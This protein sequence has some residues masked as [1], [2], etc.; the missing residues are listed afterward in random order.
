MWP[1]I[2]IGTPHSCQGHARACPA[3][4]VPSA[5]MSS[6][7]LPFLTSFRRALLEQQALFGAVATA[8]AAA[9]CAATTG[10]TDVADRPALIRNAN[11]LLSE[12]PV[13]AEALERSIEAF[14]GEAATGQF[15]E[16]CVDLS[17]LDKHSVFYRRVG[18]FGETP[19][20]GVPAVLKAYTLN[21]EDYF[22]TLSFAGEL[23][24]APFLDMLV[25]L[26]A[27]PYGDG[28]RFHCPFEERTRDFHT[29]TMEDVRFRYSGTFDE[30]RAREF[31]E[32]RS[33]LARIS[34]LEREPLEYFAF[35]SLDEMLKSYGLVFDEARC[36][37]LGHDLGRFDHGGKRYVTGMGDECYMYGY[38]GRFL[39]SE[40]HDRNEAFRTMVT[41]FRTLFG[42][43]WLI[44]TPIETLR[45]ELRETIEQAPDLDLVEVFQK[46]RNGQTQ[47]HAPSLVMAALICEHALERSDFSGLLRLVHSGAKGERFFGELEAVLGIGKA[48]FRDAILQMSRSRK[49]ERSKADWARARSRTGPKTPQSGPPQRVDARATR[50][51]ASAVRPWFRTSST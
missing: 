12:D 14:L 49:G 37:F 43:Y 16:N 41:G 51:Q 9:S 20:L 3:A 40:A 21:N 48:Q 4:S 50:G 13:I 34:G 19:G 15:T 31:L 24:G 28:Y 30:G 42:G 38:A 7:P 23:N 1:R 6:D 44:G 47:G 29:T 11:V 10:T 46:G 5:P 32:V 8:F 27:T 33:E 45:A 22:V 26:K 17:E 25:E 2:R 36:N 18:G 35:Q 39:R